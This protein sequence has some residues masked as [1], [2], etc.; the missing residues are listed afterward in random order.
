MHLDCQYNMGGKQCCLWWEVDV[1][2]LTYI[3]GITKIWR[4]NKIEFITG[5]D[6][7]DNS[8]SI[9]NYLIHTF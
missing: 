8:E 3:V 7:L 9:I 2:C 5:M 6:D 1:K 4:K